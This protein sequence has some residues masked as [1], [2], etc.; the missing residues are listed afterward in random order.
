VERL[1]ARVEGLVAEGQANQQR[2]SEETLALRKEVC[3][4]IDTAENG[5]QN[6]QLREQLAVSTRQ[7]E[8]AAGHLDELTK[9]ARAT[10]IKLAE[11]EA[12]VESKNKLL[13][14]QLATLKV[15]RRAH[16]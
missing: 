13:L 16:V 2:R 14:E 8:T 5:V 15:V 3:Y 6:Q 12:E 10:A 9:S 4:T 7:A 1:T 11:A